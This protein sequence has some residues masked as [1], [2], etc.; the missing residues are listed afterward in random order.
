LT[1]Y[2][3]GHSTRSLEE[4]AGLLEQ[5]SIALLADVR[6]V[7]GSRRLPHFG[8]AVLERELPERGIAYV[9]LPELGGLR[10][11]RPGSVNAGW[12]NASF[13]GYADYMQ[14]QEFVAALDSLMRTAAERRTAVM[15][16][17]AVPWRCHRSLLA[18]ALTV[19]G[20]Q[21]LHITGAGRPQAHSLTPFA[22]VEDGR[23]TYPDTLA[24]K[25]DG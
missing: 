17:E 15:C 9:H 4:L 13:R 23:L 22:Q 11:P 3:I 14:T 7:P 8:K 19:R 5:N 20:V 1:V 25:P 21:V 2:T 24:L 18:D 12:R 10:K 16:A 6:T